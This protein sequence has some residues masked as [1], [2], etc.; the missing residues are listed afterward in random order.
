M[1]GICHHYHELTQDNQHL[2]NQLNI[3]IKKTST[4]IVSRGGNEYH[5]P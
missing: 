4:A 1:V 3:L 5:Q 2:Y